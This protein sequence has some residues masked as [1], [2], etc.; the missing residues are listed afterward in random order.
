MLSKRV[1]PLSQG[2]SY[3]NKLLQ[4][5]LLQSFPNSKLQ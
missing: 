3:Y 1:A 4:P 5:I 2:G